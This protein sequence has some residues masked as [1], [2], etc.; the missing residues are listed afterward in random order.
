VSTPATPEELATA[1]GIA[2][3]LEIQPSAVANW[4]TRNLGF[5]EPWGTFGSVRLYRVAD[6]LDWYDARQA[7]AHAARAAR[8]ER[9]RAQLAR[10]ESE[11]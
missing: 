9:L 1:S 10:L 3:L 7:N 4:A 5:P 8:V 2:R 6:V 11:S